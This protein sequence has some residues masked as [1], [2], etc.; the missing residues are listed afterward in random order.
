[1]IKKEG[2]KKRQDGERKVRE[3]DGKKIHDKD[4]DTL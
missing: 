4:R 1:M 2:S 3:I